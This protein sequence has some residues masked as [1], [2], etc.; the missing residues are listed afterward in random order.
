MEKWFNLLINQI[1]AEIY[2]KSTASVTLRWTDIKPQIKEL[3][4]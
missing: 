1:S 4:A 2:E 3:M